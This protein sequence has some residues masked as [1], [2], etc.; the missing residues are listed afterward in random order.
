MNDL[1]V[2]RS[3]TVNSKKIVYENVFLGQALFLQNG[4]QIQSPYEQFL[5][6]IGAQYHYV[7]FEAPQQA[8]E[9]IKKF[10]EILTL[11]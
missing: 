9:I 10:V 4:F 2:T 6:M 11:I 5:Q 8:V 7:D 1:E 3:E